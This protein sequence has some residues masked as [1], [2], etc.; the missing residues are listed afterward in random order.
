MQVAAAVTMAMVMVA[1]IIATATTTQRAIY[2]RRVSG[3]AFY[4]PIL[5]AASGIV[6]S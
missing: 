1:T 4:W 3:N 2:C 5:L 6:K